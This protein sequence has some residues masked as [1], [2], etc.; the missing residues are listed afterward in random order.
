MATFNL[1][2]EPAQI[3]YILQPGRT[4]IQTYQV[5]NESGNPITLTTSVEA[6]KPK[7]N[8]GSVSYDNAILNSNLEFT[9]TNSDIKLGD[10]FTLQPKSEK[11]LV[12]KIKSNPNSPASDTYATFF[13]TQNPGLVPG[14]S[15][16]Q[17]IVKIGSHLLLT[18]SSVEQSNFKAEITNFKT[19]PKFK[20][21]LLNQI[22][23]S[24]EIN[25]PTDFFFKTTGTISI[26]KND[27]EIKKIELDSLNVLSHSN[28]QIQCPPLAPPFWPG[29]YTATLTLSQNDKNISQSISFFVFPYIFIIIIL[30]LGASFSFLY[31]L[32]NKPN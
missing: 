4:I 11:Q 19:F 15:Q 1:S 5:R 30:F 2:I 8:D 21:I 31:W 18:T 14:E 3:E 9:F 20:D 32:K 17:A 7:S 28:R 27:L 24:A 13:V 16:S 6:W 12:L 22:T 23:L 29:Q 25:N 26:T 10:S